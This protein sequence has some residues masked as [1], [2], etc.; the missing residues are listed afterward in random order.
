MSKAVKMPAMKVAATGDGE[1]S[2][3]KLSFW[4]DVARAEY[5]KVARAWE[6][7]GLDVSKVPQSPEPEVAL[8]AALKV[9]GQAKAKVVKRPGRGEGFVLVDLKRFSAA[10]MPVA[11]NR[12]VARSVGDDVLLTDEYGSP[13]TDPDC[14]RI[15]GEYRAIRCELSRSQ[16]S[17][18]FTGLIEECEGVRLRDGGGLYWVMAQHAERWERY[19]RAI[20][21]ATGTSFENWP[22]YGT[23]QSVVAGVMRG[24]ESE[25]R[26]LAKGIQDEC[27]ATIDQTKDKLGVDGIETRRRLIGTFL[28]K[29]ATFADQV[30]A[31]SAITLNLVRT[32]QT[33]L[34]NVLR[35][36]EGV[37]AGRKMDAPRVLE[38]DDPVVK[39]KTEVELAEEAA[40]D[41]ASKRMALV[42]Q[43]MA[44]EVVTEADVVEEEAE[45][46]V[47]T[48][49]PSPPPLPRVARYTPPPM[50]END[51]AA[52]RFGLIELD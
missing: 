7:A 19:C 32:V 6:A 1:S 41:I 47:K 51:P 33:N 17:S 40:A 9:C 4:N 37:A 11:M 44:E 13:S 26:R 48:V 35:F 14:E 49:A 52:N 21:E 31:P 23:D 30:G 36:A 45:P 25:A 22:T 15:R 20:S 16:F 34:A 46:E 8:R 18:W 2:N 39:P 43:G 29:V 10:N 50:V 28:G 27:I 12:I 42:V 38:L 24:I 3:G 5:A